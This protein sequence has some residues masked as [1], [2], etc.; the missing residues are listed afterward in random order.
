ML[1]YRI[2]C[3]VLIG[4]ALRLR[5]LVII[6][7]IHIF[8]IMQFVFVFVH[9][10]ILMLLGRLLIRNLF[11]FLIKFMNERQIV[12][13]LVYWMRDDSFQSIF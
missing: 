2:T 4:C 3:I 13:G 1:V 11:H 12:I 8:C 6:L 5:H 9:V 10:A 7:H